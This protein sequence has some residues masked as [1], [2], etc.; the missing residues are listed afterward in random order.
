MFARCN[1]MLL[2]GTIRGGTISQQ[3]VLEHLDIEKE[4]RAAAGGGG[5]LQRRFA[6]SASFSRSVTQSSFLIFT[7]VGMRPLHARIG[8]CMPCVVL[9]ALGHASGQGFHRVLLFLLRGSLFQ[10]SAAKRRG[11]SLKKIVECCDPDRFLGIC[12]L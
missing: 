9:Q 3:E 6:C 2:N 8:G 12:H 7:G 5:R 4:V 1:G 11:W 10:E